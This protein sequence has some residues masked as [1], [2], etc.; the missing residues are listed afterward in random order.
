[1]DSPPIIF[2]LGL[3]RTGT[4]VLYQ[5]L[6]ETG[7]FEILTAEDVVGFSRG[8][9]ASADWNGEAAAEFA[10]LERL[11][12]TS[13]GIDAIPLGP[14]TPEEYGF[15]LSNWHAGWS[16]TQRN[17]GMFREMCAALRRRNP[18]RPLLVKN[19]WDFGNA[20][21]IWSQFPDARFVFLHRDPRETL[22][23][24]LR[25]MLAYLNDRSPYLAI[26]S[27]PYRRFAETGFPFRV[28][29]W[30]SAN[31]ADWIV[32]A[33]LWHS[34]GSVAG[35][36]RDHGLVPTEQCFDLRFEDLCDD[37]LGVV[38]RLLGFLQV[39]ADAAP[40]AALIQR[41]PVRAV[42][43]V[44]RQSARIRKAFAAYAEQLGYDLDVAPAR[45]DHTR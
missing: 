19:P 16:L 26:L 11:G 31:R 6:A 30:F 25:M 13:R 45:I 36:L 35:Y 10:A 23:S 44:E 32:R 41:P 9:A 8:S 28:A 29:R 18:D 17:V 7:A 14:G 21:W 24:T 3:H 43:E 33:A 37:S 40:L 42:A 4:T 12:H 22:S 38:R 39:D 20:A 27:E 34:S 15:V 1:M 5:L 2:I